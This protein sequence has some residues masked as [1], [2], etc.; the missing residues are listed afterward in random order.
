M[1]TKKDFQGLYYHFCSYST[2]ELVY[3]QR[4]N[5]WKSLLDHIFHLEIIYIIK[6]KK[7]F[8]WLCYHFYPLESSFM[9]VYSGV[10][11]DIQY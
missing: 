10:V 6:T 11:G 5:S 4:S 2:V 7:H 8:W 1:D 9:I 3:L